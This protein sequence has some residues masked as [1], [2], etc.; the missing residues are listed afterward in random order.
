MWVKDL[1][2]ELIAKPFSSLWYIKMVGRLVVWAREQAWVAPGNKQTFIPAVS[3]RLD[4]QGATDS[5]WIHLAL[6]KHVQRYTVLTR[7]GRSTVHPEQ[8]RRQLSLLEMLI[9]W[10]YC[11]ACKPYQIAVSQRKLDD[12]AYQLNFFL[13]FHVSRAGFALSVSCMNKLCSLTASPQQWD[14]SL[15]HAILC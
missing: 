1:L 15:S 13:L 2:A 10:W 5:S 12:E 3:C 11:P 9:A 7:P 4:L 8:P 6:V 14:C